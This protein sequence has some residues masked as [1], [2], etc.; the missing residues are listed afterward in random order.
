[1]GQHGGGGAVLL[2]LEEI[3]SDPD[4]FPHFHSQGHDFEI[5]YADSKCQ[6]S[7][8]LPLVAEMYF[9]SGF[10][11]IDAIVGIDCSVICEPAGH[12]ATKWNMPMVSHICTST[13]L[14]DKKLYPTFART[15]APSYK[16]APMFVEIMRH[17]GY[18]RA[19]IFYAS[20]HIQVL[21]AIAVKEE[22]LRVGIIL[23][24][25]VLFIPGPEG[26]E[27]EYLALQ[28][29]REHTRGMSLD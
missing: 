24:D 2:A 1:M 4:N 26:K 27:Q 8:G 25:F 18:D 3:M 9:G 5:T 21:S 23:T 10:P 6:R 16:T 22:F 15:V 28:K 17:F 29:A 14:S 12:L 7:V 19:A 20:D 13:K 11:A